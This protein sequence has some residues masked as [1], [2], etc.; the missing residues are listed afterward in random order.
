[1]LNV[2]QAGITLLELMIS[3]AI[4]IFLLGGVTA[5]WL[6]MRTTTTETIALSELQQNGRMAIAML[7]ADIQQAGFRGML[8]S[9]LGSG[10]TAPAPF[11]GD[12]NWGLNGGS[13]PQAALGNFPTLW[14]RTMVAGGGAIGCVVNAA[15]NSDIIQIKR[16]AG[17]AVAPG[18]LQANR[19]YLES[20]GNQG[21]IFPGPAGAAGLERGEIW[22]HLHHV[23]FVTNENFDGT[24]V[25]VLARMELQNAGG[26]VMQRAMLLDGIERIRFY[27][28]TDLNNDF[29]ID[30]Y[31]AANNMPA[32]LWQADARIM[33]VKVV[34][35]VRA[36]R[37]DNNYKNS[38]GYDL[39]DGVLYTPD[40]N[41]RRMLFSTT[42][43]ITN[44]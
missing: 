39:G 38:S 40:D 28:G 41:F 15:A 30:S 32:S 33:A 19:F 37:A 27:Y 3:L 22:P 25:P 13:F 29:E 4:G 26:P 14:G 31:L 6:A 9:F 11:A 21:I 8:P 20:N 17:P 2:K 5:A 35:L 16:G 10:M 34:V 7:T 23:Y 18:A 43:S 36:N 42:V 24:S 1:M 44:P 12:C